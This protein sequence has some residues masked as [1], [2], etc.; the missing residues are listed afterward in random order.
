MQASLIPT[1]GCTRNFFFI[2]LHEHLQML[3]VFLLLLYL[4]HASPPN[5][6]L[7]LLSLT[8]LIIIIQSI[9]KQQ[10]SLALPRSTRLLK[11]V[12]RL[13]PPLSVHTTVAS[14]RQLSVQCCPHSRNLPVNSLP[15][16]VII[17]SRS[18]TKLA[19]GLPWPSVVESVV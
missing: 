3:N 5:L 4:P 2:T 8:S 12:N 17:A 9:F 14:H 16:P 13:L 15:S 6:A 10:L 18:L 11:S 7:L 1:K 19:T